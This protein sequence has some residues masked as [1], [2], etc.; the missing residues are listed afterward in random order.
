LRPEVTNFLTV[1]AVFS[2]EAEAGPDIHTLNIQKVG[3]VTQNA[4]ALTAGCVAAL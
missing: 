1:Q 2:F 3:P 4:T